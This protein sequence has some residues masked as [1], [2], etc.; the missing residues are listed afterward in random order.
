MFLPCSYLPVSEAIVSL[1]EHDDR[2]FSIGRI[3]HEGYKG[4]CEEKE[5][6]QHCKLTGEHS[7]CFCPSAIYWSGRITITTGRLTQLHN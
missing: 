1:S 4:S 6:R 5:S 2:R 3:L 7:M